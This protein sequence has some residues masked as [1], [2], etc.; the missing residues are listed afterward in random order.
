[1]ADPTLTEKLIFYQKQN[2]ISKSVARV[3]SKDTD[4]LGYYPS[5]SNDYRGIVDPI[6]LRFTE[7]FLQSID[8]PLLADETIN[9]NE[10]QRYKFVIMECHNTIR[11]MPQQDIQRLVEQSVRH[12]QQLW[13]EVNL[14]DL[15]SDDDCERV[16]A[17]I[18]TTAKL[19]WIISCMVKKRGHLKDNLRSKDVLKSIGSLAY[20]LQ[21]LLGSVKTLNL[22]NLLWHGFISSNVISHEIC[23]FVLVCTT[24]LNHTIKLDHLTL[25]QPNESMELN[26]LDP[27]YQF[28]VEQADK[29]ISSSCLV[30]CEHKN[31]WQY[32]ASCKEHHI[33]VHLNVALLQHAMRMLHVALVDCSTDR[34]AAQNTE[35]YITFDEIFSPGSLLN[36]DY[37]REGASYYTSVYLQDFNDFDTNLL[38]P[39]LGDRF[40]ALMDIFVHGYGLRLRDKLSH[41]EISYRSLSEKL[42]Q[43]IYLTSISILSLFTDVL[44]VYPPKYS[45]QFHPR[46]I[47]LR[48]LFR[49]S[50]CRDYLLELSEYNTGETVTTRS[51]IY[52]DLETAVCGLSKNRSDDKYTN[53]IGPFRIMFYKVVVSIF[54]NFSVFCSGLSESIT[55]K[56]ESHRNRSLRSRE[57]KNLS[58]CSLHSSGSYRSTII[59]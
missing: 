9:Y 21:Y 8:S 28:D 20:V 12:L 18:L 15:A 48:H 27:L 30:H 26:M 13:S 51:Q 29:I 4:D 25:R 47:I 59:V 42:S 41:G 22:K 35:F 36:S 49:I 40:H 53:F 32:L 11:T 45:Q 2:L 43:Q 3:F 38:L 23:H 16:C 1:M 57:R 33:K 44:F 50:Q 54:H 46:E 14:V 17:L 5:I 37:P 34:L 19:D 52:G 10:Y 24:T 39:L 55:S 7:S 58:A 56:I 31:L 6:T